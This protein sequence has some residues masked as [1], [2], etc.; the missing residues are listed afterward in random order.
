MYSLQ[1]HGTIIYMILDIW[2]EQLF[3]FPKKIIWQFKTS[4]KYYTNH[5]AV[6]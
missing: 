6:M 1:I 2:E 4:H 5:H 3:G